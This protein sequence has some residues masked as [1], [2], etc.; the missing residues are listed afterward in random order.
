MIHQVSLIGKRPTNEDNHICKSRYN[1]DYYA[2]FD[3]HG[4]S[5]VSKFLSETMPKYFNP[6]NHFLLPVVEITIL[7]SLF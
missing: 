3:G 7:F 1:Y 2:I 5:T 4:G 6:F